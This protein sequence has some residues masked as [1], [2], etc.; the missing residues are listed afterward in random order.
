M[1]DTA[2]DQ[3]IHACLDGR[4]TT[5]EL[6]RLEA[7]LTTDA[8]ARD[9]YLCLADLHACL[10]TDE[11]L[12][13]PTAAAEPRQ[14]S[15]PAGDPLTSSSLTR[16]TAAAA[17]GLLVGLCSAGLAFGYVMPV[18]ARP[19]SL[20]ADGFE[21]GPAP[22]CRGLVARPGIWSGDTAEVL[23][24]DQGVLPAEGRQMLR[25]LRADY[26]GKSAT[27]SYISDTYRLIDLGP[28]QQPLAT[29]QAIARLRAHFNAAP[30]PADEGYTAGITAMAF[31]TVTAARLEAIPD[32]ELAEQALAM[33]QRRHVPIDRQPA[34]WQAI[35]CELRLP[36]QSRF[37]LLRLSI[38]HQHATQRRPSFAGHYLDDVAVTLEQSPAAV[39]P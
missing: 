21:S 16:P 25:V 31:D 30:F 24:T 3:L 4:A 7:I 22:E 19:L 26:P 9:R 18:L 8:A 35:D 33:T 2:L 13:Q 10:A 15:S 17:V 28:F 36:P 12:W 14:P 38:S 6:A 1:P 37:L 27:D 20:F 11:S 34:S 23:A 5:D 29:G 32:A 39:Q